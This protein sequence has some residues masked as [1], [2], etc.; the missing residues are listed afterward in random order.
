MDYSEV[1]G[2]GSDERR[3]S[4]WE[5]VGR[6]HKDKKDTSRK[7]KK[8]KGSASSNGTESEEDV[9]KES[10]VRL[11]NVVVRFEGEGGVKKN[12]ST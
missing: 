12:G 3:E 8:K 11:F 9:G 2:N 4:D 7:R 1:E 10:A 5:E 6:M